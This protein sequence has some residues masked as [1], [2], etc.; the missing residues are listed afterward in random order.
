L[1]A[2][3]VGIDWAHRGR[4]GTECWAMGYCKMPR[5]KWA[6][7]LAPRRKSQESDHRFLGKGEL[8]LILSPYL[9]RRKNFQ[10][11]TKK[12]AFLQKIYRRAILH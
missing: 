10:K 6:T 4:W 3:I 12:F 11:R 7:S 8:N 1:K 5:A 2:G 9:N